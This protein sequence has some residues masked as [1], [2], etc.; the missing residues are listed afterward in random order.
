MIRQ[1][2]SSF[3]EQP[4]IE[5]IPVKEAQQQEEM[6]TTAKKKSKHSMSRKLNF[7]NSSVGAT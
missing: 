4:S 3:A 1:S 6:H 5:L 7:V 2:P